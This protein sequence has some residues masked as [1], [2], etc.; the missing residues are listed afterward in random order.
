MI[1]SFRK[2]LFS[3][4]VLFQSI[5]SLVNTQ[6]ID[7]ETVQ[8]R[9]SYVSSVLLKTCRV[10]QNTV[11]DSETYFFTAE[12]DVEMTE[13]WTDGNMNIQ[14]LP[15]NIF[16]KFPNL[17]SLSAASCSLKLV[18]KDNLQYLSSI[19]EID[20]SNNLL[21]SIE[22]GTFDDLM[23]LQF[24]VLARNKIKTLN[25]DVFKQLKKLSS[26]YLSGNNCIDQDFY[27]DFSLD[28]TMTTV[29]ENCLLFEKNQICQANLKAV[30][31]YKQ[32]CRCSDS[33]NPEETNAA[34]TTENEINEET[35]EEAAT[36]EGEA[37]TEN[38]SEVTEKEVNIN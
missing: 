18:N 4:L 11:V 36:I 30:E 21:E 2:L 7:C 20:F 12:P 6:Q 37:T 10:D 8:T 27:S 19:E 1:Y 28:E 31:K 23:I 25:G 38:E 32:T 33:E 35:T 17:I 14:Y 9:T 22:I 16:E 13:V 29:S 3:L 26:L 24:L 15:K 5:P 34:E